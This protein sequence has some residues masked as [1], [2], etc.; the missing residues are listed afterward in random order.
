MGTFIN[1][2]EI[3]YISVYVFYLKKEKYIIN[4]CNVLLNAEKNTK[5]F[6]NQIFK[7]IIILYKNLFLMKLFISQ[8]SFEL[9][10]FWIKFLESFNKK[11]HNFKCI[12]L[13]FMYLKRVLSRRDINWKKFLIYKGNVT[14]KSIAWD[15]KM[16]FQ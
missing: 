7:L 8:F 13:L 5:V 2:M 16:W 10:V 1:I 4:F 3:W 14:K 15:K 12:V 6:Y 9:C 11:L